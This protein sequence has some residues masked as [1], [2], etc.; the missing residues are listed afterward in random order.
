[1]IGERGTGSVGSL[2]YQELETRVREFAAGL[3]RYGAR[4]GD[5]IGLL[6]EKRVDATVSLLAIVHLG[7]LVVPLFS[8][9][10]VDAIVAR[11]NRPPRRA[12]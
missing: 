1:M 6:M 7:A 12:W 2:T 3:A 8:G 10:G 5:R 4:P 9:F 11:L